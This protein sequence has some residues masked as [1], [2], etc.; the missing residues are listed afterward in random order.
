MRYFSGEDEAV[1]RIARRCEGSLRSYTWAIVERDRSLE[2]D[3][4][5]SAIAEVVWRS[6][7]GKKLRNAKLLYKRVVWDVTRMLKRMNVPKMVPLSEEVEEAIVDD[8]ELFILRYQ[9]QDAVDTLRVGPRERTAAQLLVECWPREEIARRIGVSGSALRR[10]IY[11][12]LY[13]QLREALV[14]A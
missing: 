10:I 8:E 5:V 12:V 2:Q 11:T 1:Y 3:D 9:L 14:G 7:S 13:P 4:V 6:L